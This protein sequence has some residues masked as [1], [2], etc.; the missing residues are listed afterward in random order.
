VEFQESTFF[1][2]FTTPETDADTQ[3]CADSGR[4]I[5]WRS[6]T[7]VC[8]TC[9]VENAAEIMTKARRRPLRI[10]LIEQIYERASYVDS[11]SR[12]ICT[13]KVVAAEVVE[14]VHVP[15]SRRNSQRQLD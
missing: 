14:V 15:R 6:E 5:T 3:Q 10:E 1:R 7:A 9:S 13:D 11:A 2:V 12:T 4:L 8:V